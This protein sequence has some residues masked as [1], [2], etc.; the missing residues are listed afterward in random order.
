MSREFKIGDK[1]YF[2]KKSCKIM[3]VY[4]YGLASFPIRLRGRT[5]SFNRDGNLLGG[6]MTPSIFHATQEN[7]A[8]LEK[9]YGMEFEAPPRQPTSCEIIIAMLNN[10]YSY[11]PCYVSS[12]LEEPNGES[13]LD[14]II[15]VKGDGRF[16]NQFGRGWE[17]ATPFDPRTGQPITE[18]PQ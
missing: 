15:C 7:H 9:L 16:Y 5:E 3:T 8:L 11:V 1:V 10:G 12:D 14:F 18:L 2:P 13:H 6:D 4:E 17:Y